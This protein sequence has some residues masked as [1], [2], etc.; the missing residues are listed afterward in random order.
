MIKVSESLITLRG[1][2][3]KWVEGLFLPTAEG[4]VP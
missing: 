4:R 1:D 2:T 3:R